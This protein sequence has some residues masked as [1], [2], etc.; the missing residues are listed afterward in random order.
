MVTITAPGIQMSEVD[1]SF[2]DFP[3]PKEET[4]NVL[5]TGFAAKGH[6]NYP[7]EFTN[8]NTDDDLIATFGTPT[9][10]AERYFFNTCSEAIKREKTVL[11]AT[12]LPYDNDAGKT[13]NAASFSVNVANPTKINALSGDLSSLC[14]DFE[15]GNK[16]LV[17]I[18]ANDLTSYNADDVERFRL[19]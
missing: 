19:S 18:N 6:N 15:L 7:Y 16:Y 8:K 1:L 4:Q 14:T 17:E 12:R 13:Y 3:Q 9:T 11:Y 10:E 2:Y 5:V